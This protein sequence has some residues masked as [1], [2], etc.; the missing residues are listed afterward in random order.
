MLIGIEKGRVA[1]GGVGGVG[2]SDAAG[3]KFR[4]AIRGGKERNLRRST[5]WILFTSL[6]GIRQNNI[7]PLCPG[8]R[9]C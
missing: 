6:G 5:R 1:A 7:S 4:I 9:L 8:G 2:E 3:G